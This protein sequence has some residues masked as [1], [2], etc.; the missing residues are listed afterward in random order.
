MP[1]LFVST[2]TEQPI[3]ATIAILILCIT[4]QILDAVPQVSAVHPFLLTHYW[5]GFG[6]LLRDPIATGSVLT[7]LG[8]FAAY[9]AVFWTAAWAPASPARTSPADRSDQDPPPHPPD[10]RRCRTGGRVVDHVVADHQKGIDPG[11]IDHVLHHAGH[12]P[13]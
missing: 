6:D 10:D 7:S 9:G 11:R 12:H 2:L 8:V 13:R 5:L 4:S 3:G 1:G